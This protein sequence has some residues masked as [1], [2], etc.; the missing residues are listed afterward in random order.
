MTAKILVADDSITIQKIVAMAFENE[1]ATVEGINNG[2]EALARIK[3]FK[4]NIVLADIDMPGLTG[5]EL[6]RKIKESNEFNSIHVMLLASDFEEFDENL[7]QASLADNH[8]TKPFKSEDLVRKVMALLD[9]AS[10]NVTDEEDEEMEEVIE[11]SVADRVIEDVVMDLG[12]DQQMD[13]HEEI[14]LEEEEAILNLPLNQES[15]NLD[16][17]DAEPEAFAPDMNSQKDI[18]L[19]EEEAILN[20]SLNQE[21]TNFDEEDAEPEAFAAGMEKNRLEDD[22]VVSDPPPEADLPVEVA[23]TIDDPVEAEEVGTP[24]EDLDELLLK[25]EELSRKSEEISDNGHHEKL[26]PMEAIDEMLKEVSALKED[27]LFASGEEENNASKTTEPQHSTDPTNGE[28]IL[29]DVDH[30]SE[31]NAEALATAFDEITNGNKNPFSEMVT[32]L[33]EPLESFFQE[34]AV[35]QEP[36]NPTENVSDP[37]LSTPQENSLPNIQELPSP[38]SN[39][40]PSPAT[41]KIVASEGRDGDM[42]APEESPLPEEGQLNQ[43]ME[44]EVRKILQE[45]LAPLIEKEISG[46]SEKILRAVEENVR[47]VTPGIAK[48]IIEK[49]IDKIKTMEEG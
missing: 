47:Q 32:D 3:T 18:S 29:A 23:A 17:E 12:D 16:E 48:A 13:S 9:N 44:K 38:P 26:S 19:E 28:A 40:E 1:D 2:S 45:S 22:S 14:S 41:E 4:P 5:F 33:S 24:E 11:L 6:S 36:E 35:E 42:E 30:I 7:F 46:L 10:T 21:S 43:F 15:T 39:G 49:E 20:L 31:E 8:I 37:F 34:D 25:V 27:S